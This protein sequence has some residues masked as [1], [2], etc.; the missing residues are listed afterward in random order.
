MTRT[1][2]DFAKFLESLKVKNEGPSVAHNPVFDWV[3]TASSL[4]IGQWLN[5]PF[6]VAEAY[7]VIERLNRRVVI[8][9]SNA[10]PETLV[11]DVKAYMRQLMRDVDLAYAEPHQASADRRHRAELAC[12]EWLKV[13][14]AEAS[15]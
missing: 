1:T 12:L 13:S 14:E 9:E 5:Q 11:E 15:K 2:Q 10:K 6:T 4:M 7:R 3:D 8:A